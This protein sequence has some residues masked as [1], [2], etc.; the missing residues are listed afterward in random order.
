MSDTGL[1]GY[2][3]QDVLAQFLA[4]SLATD[5][6]SKGHMTQQA[7]GTNNIQ[8]LLKL[9]LDP[10]MGMMTG[11]FHPGAL[12]GGAPAPKVMPAFVGDLTRTSGYMNA[13]I[14]GVSDAAAGFISGKMDPLKA[15]KLIQDAALQ[16]LL[17]PEMGIDTTVDGWQEGV[18]D[19]AKEM[20]D[21]TSKYKSAA[22]QYEAEK[23]AFDANNVA[24][25]V[26]NVFSRAGLPQPTEQYDE[27]TIP[28]DSRYYENAEKTSQA[29]A[30]ALSAYEKYIANEK[31]TAAPVMQGT[32]M[33]P[34]LTWVPDAPTSAAEATSVPGVLNRNS[35]VEGAAAPQLNQGPINRNTGER[36]PA[37]PPEFLPTNSPASVNR[38]SLVEALVSG[39]LKNTGEMKPVGGTFENARKPGGTGS[40]ASSMRSGE[41]VRPDKKKNKLENNARIT[42]HAADANGGYARGAAKA[43]QAAGRSPLNDAMTARLQTLIQMGLV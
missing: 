43:A 28:M 4:Q 2:G 5:K 20:W 1:Y 32:E 16:G 15:T 41:P 21:E 11:S 13:G 7:K 23:V 3:S 35:G 10:Q 14:P 29:A 18:A 17:P 19:L 39:S 34:A 25:P 30:A 33:E 27:S 36:G 22:A 9:M 37:L 38:N 26:D 42:A 31:P 6:D 12:G 40:R 8:D 24:P